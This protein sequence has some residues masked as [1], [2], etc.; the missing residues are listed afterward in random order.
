MKASEVSCAGQPVWPCWPGWKS[1]ASERRER[2]RNE[3]PR[4]F[5]APPSRAGAR[6]A[7]MRNALD[8]DGAKV[9]HGIPCRQIP[10]PK[11]AAPTESDEDIKREK[12]R[13][14]APGIF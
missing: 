3:G 7:V 9:N 13:E 4:A 12:K 14:P 10:E 2:A 6:A 5:S 1:L 11:C 8:K